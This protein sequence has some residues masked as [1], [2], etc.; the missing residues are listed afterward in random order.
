MIALV[1]KSSKRVP[2]PPPPRHSASSLNCNT[3]LI[4]LFCVHGN[5]CKSRWFDV[6]LAHTG[7]QRHYTFPMGNALRAQN[8]LIKFSDRNS[9]QS[10][11][12]S[13]KIVWCFKANFAFLPTLKIR[14]FVEN[15]ILSV[16]KLTFCSPDFFLSTENYFSLSV[17]PWQLQKYLALSAEQ[18]KK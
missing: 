5:Q 4:A 13:P 17:S 2:P 1:A 14:T 16:L 15:E 9:V 12:K 18:C 11:I 10:E 8:F 3:R 7:V 6:R